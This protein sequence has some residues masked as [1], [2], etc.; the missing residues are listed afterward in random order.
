MTGSDSTVVP[1]S[2]S[3]ATRRQAAPP[4]ATTHQ[5]V[6]ARTKWEMGLVIPAHIT[7]ALDALG[8]AGVDVH[9]PEIDRACGVE[10]PTLDQWEEGTLYPRWEQL[11][12]LS[13]VT[14]KPPG[15]FMAPV[16]QVVSGLQ[17]SMAFHVPTGSIEF[18]VLSYTRTALVAARQFGVTADM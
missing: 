8:L 3:R 4:V 17:T 18:P 14:G 16:Q 15:Y 6:A 12:R 5:L 2:R 7:Q 10:E 9:G 1:L 13:E 11:L